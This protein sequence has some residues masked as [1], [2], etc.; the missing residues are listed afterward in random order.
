MILS[1]MNP[2]E[3][4]AL[5]LRSPPMVRIRH[6]FAILAIALTAGCSSGADISAANLAVAHFRELMEMQQF[7][8][9]YEAS[10]DEDKKATTEQQWT[11]F[12]TAIHDKLGSVKNAQSTGWNVNYRTTGIVIAISYKT[13]FEKGSGTET[14]SYAISGGTAVLL[15]YH[16][17]ST[18]PLTN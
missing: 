5:A 8:Q 16:I 11:K 1:A 12:L 10:A 7:R 14:F 6:L 9:I 15:G 17:N 13:E 3:R 4:H 2:F 18:D